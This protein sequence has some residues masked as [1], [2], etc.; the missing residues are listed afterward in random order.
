MVPVIWQAEKLGLARLSQRV[1]ELAAACNAGTVPP[2][3]LTGGSF[4]VSNLGSLGVE[5]FTPVLNPPQV[6]I[7]GVGCPV[8]RFKERDGNLHLISQSGCRL[9]DHRAVDGAGSALFEGDVREA[10][11]IESIIEAEREA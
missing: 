3:D 5:N 2:G 9:P 10:E 1:K 8:T 7:L 11:N 6:G 4:T